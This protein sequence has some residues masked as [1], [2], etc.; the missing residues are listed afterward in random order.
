[1]RVFYIMQADSF[2]YA[3]EVAVAN[4]DKQSNLVVV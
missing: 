3:R 4:L 1:M 2:C